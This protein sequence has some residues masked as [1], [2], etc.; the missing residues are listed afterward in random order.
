[1]PYAESH[2]RVYNDRDRR[3]IAGL[4]MGGAQTMNISFLHLDKFSYI[5]V[6][7]SGVIGGGGPSAFETSHADGLNNAA[8]KKGLHLVWFRTGVDDSLLERS[9]KPTVAMLKQH[10]FN[11]YFKE[12]PGAHSWTN[13]RN[14][15]TEF[16]GQ[17]FQ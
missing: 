10:G 6:F 11:V 16:A 17:L 13:W 14:Y 2:Y 12:S 5:G 1:M 8:L 4:S 15:L 3:A 7:S 9:T